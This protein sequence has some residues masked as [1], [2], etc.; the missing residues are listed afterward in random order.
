MEKDIKNNEEGY[1]DTDIKNDT[2]LEEGSLEGKKD[3]WLTTP[4]AILI[5]CAF[6]GMGIFAS[7]FVYKN[8]SRSKEGIKEE[9]IH[10]ISPKQI[11]DLANSAGFV[12]NSD[13]ILSCLEN[14]TMKDRVLNQKKEGSEKGAEGTPYNIVYFTNGESFAVPGAIPEDKWIEVIDSELK[15]TSGASKDIASLYADAYPF[16]LREGVSP[17]VVIM[18]YSDIDCPFC[19][20]LHPILKNVVDHYKGK[21]VWVYRHNPLE[22]HPDAQIKAEAVEC[23]GKADGPDA[24]WS[25]LEYVMQE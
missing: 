22:K 20:R 7:S 19:K 11:F 10:A 15:K 3:P 23:I 6:I 13:N 2:L 25:Y 8:T 18:E 16:G 21:V 24:F 1:T 12:K 4:V 9:K 14:R 17:Q 5:G